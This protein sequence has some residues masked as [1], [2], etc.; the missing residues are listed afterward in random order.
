MGKYLPVFLWMTAGHILGWLQAN[1]QFAWEWW[2]DKP[3][4]TASI[5]AVPTGL[6]FWYGSRAGYEVFSSV[7]SVRFI[8]F[9][10]SYITFPL[11]TWVFLGEGFLNIKTLTCIMLSVIIVFIQIYWR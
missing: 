11:M 7:W 5:Y 6:L 1:S 4:F 3:F 2:Q 8:A 10:I 9:A